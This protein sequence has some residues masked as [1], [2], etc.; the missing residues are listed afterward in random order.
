MKKKGKAYK[1]TE[2][3]KFSK[4]PEKYSAPPRSFKIMK[5]LFLILIWVIGAA[6]VVLLVLKYYHIFNEH[7]H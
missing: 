1:V 2:P 3:Y 4:P 7:K 6:S 5:V